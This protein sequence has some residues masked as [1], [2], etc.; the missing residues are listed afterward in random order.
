MKR[1]IAFSKTGL[2]R[3]C[4]VLIFAIGLPVS[5]A[6]SITTWSANVLLRLIEGMDNVICRLNKMPD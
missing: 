5:V 4:A 1:K 3:I 6:F 2:K